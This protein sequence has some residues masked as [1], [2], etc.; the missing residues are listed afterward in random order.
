M[1]VRWSHNLK[2]NAVEQGRGWDILIEQ[3]NPLKA[4]TTHPVLL[5]MISLTPSLTPQ[6]RLL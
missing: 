3:E 6:A 4:P 2:E 1:A 5:K